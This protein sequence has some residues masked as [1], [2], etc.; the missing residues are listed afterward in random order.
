MS[1]KTTKGAMTVAEAGARGGARGTG[2]VKVRGDSAYYAE[3]GRAA[4]RK[5]WGDRKP[6][7][8]PPGSAGT[9]TTAEA[10]AKGGAASRG[11]AKARKKRA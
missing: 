3:L 1:E 9:V 10:G 11:A 8:E 5:R 2:R 6:A 4:M 7:A